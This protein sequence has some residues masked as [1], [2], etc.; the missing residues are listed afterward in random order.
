[1]SAGYKVS[2]AE[3]DFASREITEIY[4]ETVRTA[5]L[6]NGDN[7]SM[8]YFAENVSRCYAAQGIFVEINATKHPSENIENLNMYYYDGKVN[9]LLCDRKVPL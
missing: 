2:L 5:K 6:V 3:T 8:R 7:T 1:M 4:E 9:F